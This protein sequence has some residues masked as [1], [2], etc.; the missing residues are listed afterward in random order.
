M[1]GA[2][3]RYAFQLAK[4]CTVSTR[5]SLL[6]HGKKNWPTEGRTE[7]Q[8]DVESLCSDLAYAYNGRDKLQVMLFRYCTR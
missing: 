3:W 8:R 6:V 7:G 2:I 1:V 4:G 5:Q